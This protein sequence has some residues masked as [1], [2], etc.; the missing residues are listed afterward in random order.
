MVDQ[1]LLVLLPMQYDLALTPLYGCTA[2]ASAA[3]ALF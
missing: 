3:R 1:A 2:T